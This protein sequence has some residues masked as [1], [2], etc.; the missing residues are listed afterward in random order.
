MIFFK[1]FVTFK[2]NAE[3][4]NMVEDYKMRFEE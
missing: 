3:K 1:P 2:I 4:Q